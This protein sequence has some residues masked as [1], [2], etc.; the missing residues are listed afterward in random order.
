[1]IYSYE[2]RKIGSYFGEDLYE[3]CYNLPADENGYSFELEEY[4]NK[5][6]NVEG[7]IIL[8]DGTKIPIVFLT[9]GITQNHLSTISNL[10]IFDKAGEDNAAVNIDHRGDL[11]PKTAGNGIL[12]IQYTKVS[13]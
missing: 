10:Q 12:K 5:I 4:V 3:K 6:I 13:E 1:M 11:Y 2:E 7:F 8:T 9:D